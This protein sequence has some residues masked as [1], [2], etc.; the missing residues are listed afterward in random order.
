MGIIELS[1]ENDGD[2]SRARGAI[3]V[4]RDGSQLVMTIRYLAADIS[5]VPGIGKSVPGVLASR[6]CPDG[7][8]VNQ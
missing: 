3:L 2:L 6:P 8:L 1:I 5:S 4:L 7:C